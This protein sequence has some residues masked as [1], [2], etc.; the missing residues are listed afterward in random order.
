[1]PLPFILGGAAALLGVTGAALA[2]DGIENQ[3]KA[4]KILEQAKNRFEASKAQLE[5]QDLRLQ[6]KLEY[7]GKIYLNIGQDFQNFQEIAD[8]LLQ[9]L[10]QSSQRSL[11]IQLPANKVKQIEKVTINFNS[12][13]TSLAGGLTGGALAGAATYA[14]VMALGTASTGTAIASLSGAAASKAT[15]AALGGGALKAGGLGVMGGMAMTAGLVAAPAL[16]FMGWAYSDEAE[17]SLKKLKKA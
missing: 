8:E 5:R 6:D 10:N 4:E 3:G 15:W 2:A 7:L 9:K 13:A 14:G 16:A 1:M 12:L 11:S 17:K